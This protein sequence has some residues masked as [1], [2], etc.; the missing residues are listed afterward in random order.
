MVLPIG[1]TV[2]LPP[3]GTVARCSTSSEVVGEVNGIPVSRV[4]YGEVVGLPEATE[5]TMFVVSA[6]VRSAVPHRKDVASPGDL[7]RDAAGAVV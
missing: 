1:D 3:S 5:G 2:T 4:S 6:L 7:V